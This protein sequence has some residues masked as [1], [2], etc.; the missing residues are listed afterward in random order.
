M[1]W[2]ILFGLGIVIGVVL[3]SGLI[4]GVYGFIRGERV[5]KAAAQAPL[6]PKETGATPPRRRERKREGR[7]LKLFR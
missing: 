7:Q 3:G 2:N 6:Y 5:D 4:S 1:W